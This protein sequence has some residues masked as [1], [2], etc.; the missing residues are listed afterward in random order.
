M[1]E[2]NSGSWRNEYIT[3]GLWDEIISTLRE[4]CKSAAEVRL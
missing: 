3:I 4:P 2:A 1:S